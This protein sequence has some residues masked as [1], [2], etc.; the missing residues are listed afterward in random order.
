MLCRMTPSRWRVGQVVPTYFVSSKPRKGYYRRLHEAV[1]EVP[2]FSRIEIVGGGVFHERLVIEKPIEVGVD[3]A[4]DPPTLISKTTPLVLNVSEAYIEGLSI[5]VESSAPAA[6]S[7]I[8]RTGQPILQWCVLQGM[9]VGGNACPTVRKCRIMDSRVDGLL[10]LEEA[11]G[12]YLKNSIWGHTGYSVVVASVGESVFSYNS[13]SSSQHGQVCVREPEGESAADHAVVHPQFLLNHLTDDAQSAK[14]TLPSSNAA[15]QLNGVLPSYQLDSMD[16]KQ[17]GQRVQL[18]PVNAPPTGELDYG[19]TLENIPIIENTSLRCAFLVTG[20]RTQPVLTCNSIS[21]CQQHGLFLRGGCGG[22]YESNYIATNKG[23]GLVVQGRA[24]PAPAASAPSLPS[25]SAPPLFIGNQVCGNGGGVKIGGSAATF[26]EDNL[27]L[28]NRGPQMYVDG[29]PPDLVVEQ[30]TV[31]SGNGIGIWSANGGGGSF[32]KNKFTDCAEAIRV[33]RLADPQYLS[34]T[35]EECGIGILVRNAGRGTFRDCTVNDASRVGILVSTASRATFERCQVMACRTGAFV[36]HGG[37]GDFEDCEFTSS[38]LCGFG[39][40]ENGC[41]S[42]RGCRV[43]LGRLDGLRVFHSGRGTFTRNLFAGNDGSQVHISQDGD[44]I[45]HENVIGHGSCDGVTVEAGGLGVL[46]HNIIR[47]CYECG[48]SVSGADSAPVLRHNCIS[49][50]GYFGLS[51]TGSTMGTYERNIILRHSKASVCIAGRSVTEE[52]PQEVAAGPTA[53]APKDERIPLGPLVFRGNVLR[54]STCGMVLE[55]SAYVMATENIFGDLGQAAMVRGSSEAL[56]ICNAFASCDDGLIVDQ[57]AKIWLYANTFLS[58]DG[59]AVH[60]LNVEQ[61]NVCWNVFRHCHVALLLRRVR[62][63]KCTQNWIRHSRDCGIYLG[64]DCHASVEHNFLQDCRV[65]IFCGER[66]CRAVVSDNCVRASDR[67]SLFI[68]GD[69]LAHLKCHHNVCLSSVTG[70]LAAHGNAELLNHLCVN[71]VCGVRVSTTPPRGA[72]WHTTCNDGQLELDCTA[73][74][75]HRDATAADATHQHGGGGGSTDP[76]NSNVFRH[77]Y[78]SCCSQGLVVETASSVTFESFLLSNNDVGISIVGSDSDVSVQRGVV[79]GCAGMAAYIRSGARGR[80]TDLTCFKNFM[81]MVVEGGASPVILRCVM[82]AATVFNGY[83]S[84]SLSSPRFK[85]CLLSSRASLA[86]ITHDTPMTQVGGS[87]FVGSPEAYRLDELIRL[88]EAQR[89]Q[90]VS[91]EEAQHHLDGDKEA[92]RSDSLRGVGCSRERQ[93]SVRKGTAV[94]EPTAEEDRFLN[95]PSLWADHYSEAVVWLVTRHPAVEADEEGAPTSAVPLPCPSRRSAILWPAN[96]DHEGVLGGPGGPFLLHRKRT[97]GP[98]H[99]ATVSDPPMTTA[100]LCSGVWLDDG[101][102]P[103]FESC[104]L[105]DHCHMGSTAQRQLSPSETSLWLNKPIRQPLQAPL[106]QPPAPTHSP[107]MTP[108]RRPTKQNPSPSPSGS[109]EPSDNPRAAVGSL[110]DLSTTH[111]APPLRPD[112][113]TVLGQVLLAGSPCFWRQH[114]S[115]TENEYLTVCPLLAPPSEGPDTSPVVSGGTAARL[116]ALRHGG[117]LHPLVQKLTTASTENLSGFGVLAR[118]GARGTF[119]RCV[120][121]HNVCGAHVAAGAATTFRHCVFESQSKEALV[122]VARAAGQVRGCTFRESRANLVRISGQ[123][124]APIIEH[125]DF[126]ANPFVSITCTDWSTPRLTGNHMH[127]ILNSAIVVKSHAAPTID[128]NQLDGCTCG[129]HYQQGGMGTSEKNVFTQCVDYGIR[130]SDAGSA[131]VI[132]NN[133]FSAGKG[134]SIGVAG[135]GAAPFVLRNQMED[136]Q[137]GIA[138]RDGAHGTYVANNLHRVHT[139][140]QVTNSNGSFLANRINDS[141]HVGIKVSGTQGMPIMCKNSIV[142]GRQFGILLCHCHGRFSGNH[143]LDNTGDGCVIDGSSSQVLLVGNCLSRNG[144]CGV[145][146]TGGSKAQLCVNAINSNKHGGV[147]VEDARTSPVLEGNFLKGNHVC[148]IRFD[149]R[150]EGCANACVLSDTIDGPAIIVEDNA[151]PK[152]ESLLV[153]GNAAGG[154]LVKSGGICEARRVVFVCNGGPGP[155]FCHASPVSGS[156]LVGCLFVENNLSLQ[157]DRTGRLDITACGFL[158]AHASGAAMQIVEDTHTKVSHCLFVV[159]RSAV[160]DASFTN[161]S[162]CVFFEC[163]CGLDLSGSATVYMCEFRQCVVG[164][165]VSRGQPNI[166][167]CLFASAARYGLHL[168]EDG[169]PTVEE[170]GF[171]RNSKAIGAENHSSGIVRS[172]RILWNTDGVVVEDVSSTVF[173]DNLIYDSTNVGVLVK[174]GCP[175]FV[176]NQIF[177]HRGT[178][179]LVEAAIGGTCDANHISFPREDG[180][181]VVRT[182]QAQK[183]YSTS[184]NTV[185][186]SS[187]PPGNIRFRSL[188]ERLQGYTSVETVKE[189]NAA[190]YVSLRRCLEDIVAFTLMR[191]SALASRAANTDAAMLQW[192]VMDAPDP[193]PQQQHSAESAVHRR[194]EDPFQSRY[195]RLPEAAPAAAAF[196]VCAA[197][198]SSPRRGAST[199][200]PEAPGPQV[201]S[202]STWR[203]S[204]TTQYEA[205]QPSSPLTASVVLA[206]GGSPSKGC[207]APALAPPTVCIN[208]PAV[209]DVA[210]LHHTKCRLLAVVDAL[211]GGAG[212]L[213]DTNSYTSLLHCAPMQTVMDALSSTTAEGAWLVPV[214]NASYAETA[215]MEFPAGVTTGERVVE[216]HLSKSTVP[217]DCGT[218]PSL[219]NDRTAIGVPVPKVLPT[220]AVVKKTTAEGPALPPVLHTVKSGNASGL[221]GRAKGK[222]GKRRK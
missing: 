39:V 102:T 109:W 149:T 137:V 107:A 165:R 200:V 13:I 88:R 114:C 117:R 98:S 175:S 188:Q 162:R 99:D 33:E 185:R 53:A 23:W 156:T 30:N 17:V 127:A 56:I 1:N 68:M 193:P 180:A 170:C 206:G 29:A 78:V 133:M 54:G 89:H 52:R 213:I 177:D 211:A 202:P 204:D 148:G 118:G 222:A 10:L 135:D 181:L 184:T 101:A 2:P 166:L 9:E 152:L 112:A 49:D 154:V 26:T 130:I 214:I 125:N 103:L 100:F 18:M 40:S 72:A 3:K 108:S 93:Q 84:G 126:F 58:I 198:L 70:I 139:A 158:G 192:M 55:L 183:I 106:P 5:E 212:G 131:P 201:F 164:V 69:D 169:Q 42:V 83:V 57:D 27:L 155:A 115:D 7:V 132:A 217:T 28:R 161:Y 71:C 50:C 145:R 37:Y 173:E 110:G 172:N 80:L 51:V 97:G 96:L 22:V 4:S 15:G 189:K 113:A 12:Q 82:E 85:N 221:G 143:I 220:P 45:L 203:S 59:Y 151:K 104:Y 75:T 62:S 11:G 24:Y 32:V 124:T 111:Y 36:T 168:V 140:I 178:S 79:V 147:C 66:H 123:Q 129:I 121:R 209:P 144:G 182:T 43:T 157:V 187:S 216:R 67:A 63:G 210:L 163:G 73:S 128:R 208:L 171:L 176:G 159:S 86:C 190:S 65:G 196:V 218:L 44:P 191:V 94:V 195:D 174:N 141:L 205:E 48:V 215:R 77:S 138:L 31:T 41:P 6:A 179:F 38:R 186:N 76:V 74:T 47:T 120:F 134:V 91:Y 194:C 20:H 105:G 8:V 64:T 90:V 21:A 14:A 35:L 34:N 160:A 146:L 116:P 136:L 207:V 119:L 25:A 153:V 150:S 197:A 95:I 46:T 122:F 16:V 87:I 199:T 81:N 142:R 60:S 61:L 92:R 167:S 219:R 19:D